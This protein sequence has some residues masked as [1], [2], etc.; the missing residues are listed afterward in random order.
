MSEVVRFAQEACPASIREQIIDLMRRE[1]PEAFGDADEAVQW[2]DLP[3][4][5]PTSL[6][7]IE[8]GIVISH[9]AVPWKQIEHA[10]QTYRAFGLSEV[11]TAPAYRGKGYGLKLVKE[12]LSFIEEQSPDIGVF[13]C[14]APLIRFYAQGGWEHMQGT[15]LVGGTREKPFRSDTLGKATMM[16]FFSSK[17]QHSRSAFEGADV[18]LDLGE[19]KLW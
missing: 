6:V 4:T 12:A 10:G 7:L 8:G 1:W 11:M 17:A 19:R 15:C 18:F 9:V 3:E 5:S 13:T 2:P 16:R 14:D